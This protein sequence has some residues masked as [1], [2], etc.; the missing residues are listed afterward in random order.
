MNRDS[1]SWEH[2][3]AGIAIGA[4]ALGGPTVA[5][6]LT[7]KTPAYKAVYNWTGFYLGGHVGYGGGSFGP[8]SNPLPEQGVSFPTVSLG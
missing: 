8:G 5:A 6:D 2:V 3:L 1:L 4:L 7:F